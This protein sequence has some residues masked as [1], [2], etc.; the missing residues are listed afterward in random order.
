[1]TSTGRYFLRT[2]PELITVPKCAVYSVSYCVASRSPECGFSCI[3]LGLSS[4]LLIVCIFGAVA[5]LVCVRMTMV[6]SAGK[7]TTTVQTQ[8]DNSQTEL[9]CS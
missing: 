5:L 2:L 3:E 4:M 7:R 1:M 6:P 9:Q 8:R